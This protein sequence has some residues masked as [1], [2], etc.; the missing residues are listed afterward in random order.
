M[1]EFK[2]KDRDKIPS[3]AYNKHYQGIEDILIETNGV[4]I[5]LFT[6]KLALGGGWLNSHQVEEIVRS[7]PIKLKSG[8]KIIIKSYKLRSLDDN[9][10]P[11]SGADVFWSYEIE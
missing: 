8:D 5:L 4:E 2:I 6:N 1:N 10:L 7:Y 11:K 9:L 3:S